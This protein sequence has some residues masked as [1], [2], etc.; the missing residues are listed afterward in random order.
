MSENGSAQRAINR[1]RSFRACKRCRIYRIKCG[2]KP[3]KACRLINVECTEV[4]RPVTTSSK[5]MNSARSVSRRSTM[6]PDINS[7]AS[8]TSALPSHAPGDNH[9]DADRPYA[10][11]EHN[12][13]SWS[14]STTGFDSIGLSPQYRYMAPILDRRQRFKFLFHGDSD[15]VPP[16]MLAVLPQGTSE[17]GSAGG[18]AEPLNRDQQA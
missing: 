9:S 15:N 3:C 14:S 17:P 16:H 7:A 11:T 4:N 13:R 8:K 5:P 2:E 6:S 1:S 12:T 18:G 10:P